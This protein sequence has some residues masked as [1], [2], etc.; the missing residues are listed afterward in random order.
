VAKSAS[1]QVQ[2][3]LRLAHGATGPRPTK[4]PNKRP[5]ELGLRHTTN[6]EARRKTEQDLQL[7]S[8]IQQYQFFVGQFF[9]SL[10][11]LIAADALLLGYGVN[12]RTSGAILLASFMPIAMLLVRIELGRQALVAAYV[13]ILIEQQLGLSTDTL[14]S[15]QIAARYPAAYKGLLTIIHMEG[16]DNRLE[17]IQKGMRRRNAI[18]DS[19]TLVFLVAALI[20]LGL[21]LFVVLALWSFALL[22]AA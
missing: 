17:A 21:F 20:Q 5:K 14:I 9:Q 4:D 12:S 1:V 22:M 3:M 7:A 8:A 16:R 10:G 13:A 19:D 18:K 2:A 15:T 6:M 11:F